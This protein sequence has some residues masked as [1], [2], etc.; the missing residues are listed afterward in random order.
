MLILVVASSD[1]NVASSTLSNWQS[2][3]LF[4]RYLVYD[5]EESLDVAKGAAADDYENDN[6]AINEKHVQNAQHL[7]PSV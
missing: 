2:S 3:L 4:K 1:E 5:K 6:L 7:V